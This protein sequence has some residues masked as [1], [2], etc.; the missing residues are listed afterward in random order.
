MRSLFWRI[1][2]TVVGVLLAFALAGGW[3]A[4]RQID[5]E[6][7]VAE[8]AQTERLQAMGA[9]LEKA[10]PGPEAPQ[11]EVGLALRRWGQQLRLPLAL[12]NE[13]GERVASTP[14]FERREEMGDSAAVDAIPLS[15]GRRLLVLRPWRPRNGLPAPWG[16]LTSA[17]A[18]GFL[19]VLL[20]VGVAVGAYPV[21]R[22]LTRRLEALQRGV[23]RFG[24]GDLS[25]RVQLDGRDEVAAVAQAFNQSADRIS[26]LL[27]AHQNLVANASHELRSPLARLKMAMAL[28]GDGES[29]QPMEAEIAKN[30]SELDALIEELLL[31][32]RL[33]AADPARQPVDLLGLAAEEAAQAGI[34]LEGEWGQVMVLGDE[35]L[36][37]R[38]LRNLLENA[39]RYGGNR[40]E[41]REV[42]L[43]GW[44][45][46]QVLDRGAGVPE[47]LRDR[48]FEPFFRLPGHAEV[49]GGVGLGLALVRQI[50]R[51]HHG[52][53]RCEDRPGGG[54]CFVLRLPVA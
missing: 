46:L 16:P 27:R 12:E 13:R 45:E 5:R 48:I 53:V 6:R 39:R 28:R 23:E 2:L 20:F 7:D 44:V 11:A 22:R 25:H 14:R 30:L 4:H 41:L 29:A 37:R 21:V 8:A 17:P 31:S 54:A 33:E 34:P 50:A 36:L 52:E 32:A 3:L 19:F 51:A 35:R 18:L 49:A 10:L 38:A 26:A 42:L 1:Y 9:L 24:Q 43:P 47:L 15:D 40:Q